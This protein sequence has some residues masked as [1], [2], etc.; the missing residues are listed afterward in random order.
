MNRFK[1]DIKL[2]KNVILRKMNTKLEE[3]IEIN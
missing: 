3:G 1:E 2:S